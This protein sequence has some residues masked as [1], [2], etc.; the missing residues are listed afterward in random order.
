[1]R[2]QQEAQLNHKT[3]AGE[4]RAADYLRVS[5]ESQVD[6]NSLAA[7]ERLFMEF[8]KSR[9]WQ[10]VGIYREEGKSAHPESFRQRPV[11]RQLLEDVG[12]EHST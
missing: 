6:G 12:M 3:R 8:C 9:E 4:I 10:P 2:W 5:T 1:M 7:Q 11:F